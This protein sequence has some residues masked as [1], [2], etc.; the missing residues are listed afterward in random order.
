MILGPWCDFNMEIFLDRPLGHQFWK[1]ADKTTRLKM[2]TQWMSCLA[3]GLSALHNAK[4]KHRDL[5]PANILLHVQGD[6]VNPIIC[7]Y[8]VSKVFDVDSKS[9]KVPGNVYYMS[10]ERV[11]G[12]RTGRAGDVFSLGAIFLELAMLIYGISK[13]KLKKLFFEK[14]KRDYGIYKR[15]LNDK[16]GVFLV[17][18]TTT[19]HNEYSKQLHDLLKSMLEKDP[20]K[21]PNASEVWERTKALLQCLDM[22]PHCTA[23]SQS[24]AKSIMTQI[25]SDPDS[26]SDLSNCFE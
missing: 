16:L 14:D 26:D 9:L 3:S 11:N 25:E 6:E 12:N 22:D 15:I 10:P 4:I 17:K 8:G 5:K 23:T 7:D 13:K 19:S 24:P 21:R 1:A 20:L 2:V 18:F